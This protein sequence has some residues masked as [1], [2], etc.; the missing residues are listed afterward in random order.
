MPL[1]RI[2]IPAAMPLEKARALADLVHDSLVET[3]AVPPKDRFQLISRFSREMMIIDPNFPDVNRTAEASIVEVLFIAGRTADQ[4]DRLFRRIAE[5]A[6]AIG[7]VVDDL[8]I[9]L[10]ENT[11]ADWCAG[12]GRAFAER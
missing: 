12:Q 10:S 11:A 9:S 1:T 8:M 6:R 7:F 3:C 5:G 4:K 2:S